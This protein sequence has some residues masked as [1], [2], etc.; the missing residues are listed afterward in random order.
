MASVFTVFSLVLIWNAG[1][2]DW[3]VAYATGIA[4]LGIWLTLLSLVPF[5]S[6][7]ISLKRMPFQEHSTERARTH[8]RV[9]LKSSYA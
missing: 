4:Q 8:W 5:S 6:L 7:W 2:A 1:L 3:M 9:L